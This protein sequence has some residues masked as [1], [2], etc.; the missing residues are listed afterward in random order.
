MKIPQ[1]SGLALLT[2]RKRIRRKLITCERKM[3]IVL[4]RQRQALLETLGLIC[5]VPIT[6]RPS[7]CPHTG[8]TGKDPSPEV[9]LI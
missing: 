4:T 9:V 2:R 6:V 3:I 8:F 7:Y 1:T 5:G